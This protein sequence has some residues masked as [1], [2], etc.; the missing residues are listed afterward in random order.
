MRRYLIF[1]RKRYEEP[2]E[3]EG[4]LEAADDAAATEASRLEL[5]GDGWIEIQLVP[6][7]EIRWIV[8]SAAATTEKEAERV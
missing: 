4:D 8:G 7:A 6:E 3:L 1:A 5:G 2:L